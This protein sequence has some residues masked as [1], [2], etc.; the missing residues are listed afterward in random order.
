MRILSLRL[1]G[2]LILGV[3][4]I[5]VLSSYYEVQV[6]EHGLRR[7]S[8]QCQGAIL[9]AIFV[10][11]LRPQDHIASAGFGES[12]PV[13]SN[14]TAEGRRQNRRVDLVVSGTA[15]GS[16]YSVPTPT[17]ASTLRRRWAATTG[18][19]YCPSDGD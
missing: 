2:S 8:E 7:D 3:T 15:I 12:D 4:L 13:A 5:S 16:T 18:S 10:W 17:A 6:E 14:D 9:Y 19:S 11:F 1:I